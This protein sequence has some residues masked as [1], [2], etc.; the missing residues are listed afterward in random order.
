M[1]LDLGSD[2]GL[3]GPA[4]GRPL[5]HAVG[6]RPLSARFAR[7]QRGG[8]I[9]LEARSFFFRHGARHRAMAKATTPPVGP[10]RG[11]QPRAQAGRRPEWARKKW[12]GSRG[13]Y[14]V[15]GT[16]SHCR[17][18]LRERMPFRGAKGD[19]GLAPGHVTRHTRQLNHAGKMATFSGPKCAILPCLEPGPLATG[20]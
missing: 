18:S 3:A 10:T 17:L 11:S 6:A 19:Y 2:L 5:G 16:E 20:P 14:S 7:R 8:E 12:D 13:G 9:A 1:R 15:G 4:L